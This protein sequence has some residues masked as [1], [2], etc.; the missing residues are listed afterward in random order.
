M[1]SYL[2][3]KSPEKRFHPLVKSH[4]Q[5]VET[6]E[7]LGI[8]R[9]TNRAGAAKEKNQRKQGRY[10]GEIRESAESMTRRRNSNPTP[11][12]LVPEG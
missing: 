1:D 7:L 4:E 2:K 12:Y 6:E 9:A 10:G 3:F 11:R 5:R 8:E